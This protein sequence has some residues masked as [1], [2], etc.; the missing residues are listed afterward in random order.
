MKK[1]LKKFA[2]YLLNSELGWDP[3]GAGYEEI[4]P[5]IWSTSARAV[6]AN[7]A[8][9]EQSMSGVDPESH[10]ELKSFANSY[11][12]NFSSVTFRGEIFREASS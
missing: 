10:R 2:K 8:V 4:L 6:T 12:D 5:Y 3:Q 11:I 7:S 1:E 9:G